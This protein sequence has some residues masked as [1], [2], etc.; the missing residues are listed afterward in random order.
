[1]VR[2]CAKKDGSFQSRNFF[3][4]RI[5]ENANHF[6]NLRLMLRGR[7]KSIDKKDFQCKVLQ[8]QRLNRARRS[9]RNSFTGNVLSLRNVDLEQQDVDPRHVLFSARSVK[10]RSTITTSDIIRR[11]RRSSIRLRPPSPP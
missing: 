3:C 10:R 4:G 6:E 7:A 8:Q 9:A 1:M 11:R 5:Y 2:G